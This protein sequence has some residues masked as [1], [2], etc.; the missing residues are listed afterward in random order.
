MK[1]LGNKHEIKVRAC[2]TPNRKVTFDPGWSVDKD[3]CPD[4]HIEIFDHERGHIVLVILRPEG[5][6][7]FTHKLIGDEDYD[8]DTERST[9]MYYHMDALENEEQ[10]QNLIEEV[11]E[12]E[13]KFLGDEGSSN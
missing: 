2:L 3:P 6:Q 12:D 5:P 11:L 7:V 1:K 13:D 4:Q 10:I 9:Q 8:M